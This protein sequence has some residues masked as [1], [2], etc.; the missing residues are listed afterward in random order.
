MSAHL[1][2]GTVNSQLPALL[3]ALKEYGT[4]RASKLTMA[5]ALTKKGNDLR[6]ALYRRFRALMPAGKKILEDARARGWRM[7][8]ISPVAAMRAARLMSGKKSIMGTVTDVGGTQILRSVRIGK[9]GGR[10]YGGRRGTGGTAASAREARP[11]AQAGEVV[12]N[13]RAVETFF[14][15]QARQKGRGFLSLPWLAHRRG[16]STPK[17]PEG[18][19]DLLPNRA[20]TPLGRAQF[21][22]TA[23]GAKMT[24]TSFVEASR[25]YPAAIALAM[26]D[27]TGDIAQYFAK[28][29]RQDVVDRI[30]GKL[31]HAA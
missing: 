18:W 26:A 3:A 28:R 24:L 17:N 13:R 19:S 20:G 5:Q 25:K 15:V 9:R 27:V 7:S 10:I 14:E 4:A 12:M 23:D 11:H 31:R 2:T 1:F 30:L 22:S 16:K 29:K 8:D 21:Q 6:W